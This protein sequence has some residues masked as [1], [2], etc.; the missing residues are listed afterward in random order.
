MQIQLLF[1]LQIKSLDVYCMLNKI[2]QEQE[3]TCVAEWN[4][5]KFLQQNSPKQ[6]G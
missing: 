1:G 4:V 5:A 3:A 2:S 6:I